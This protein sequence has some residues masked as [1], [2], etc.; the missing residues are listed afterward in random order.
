MPLL[1]LQ[2]PSSPGRCKGPM[3]NVNRNVVRMSFDMRIQRWHADRGLGSGSDSRR[4]A[5]INR[6]LGSD[7]IFIEM[8]RQLKTRLK[9]VLKEFKDRQSEVAREHFETIKEN[10]DMLRDDNV[11]LEGENH[12]EFR[13][14]VEEE[15]RRVKDA[16]DGLLARPA[17]AR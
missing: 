4:K 5:I 6:R 8:Q 3:K 16:V 12:P 7:D 10:L 2:P 14:R 11:I 17:L 1:A 13:N 9:D 15:V